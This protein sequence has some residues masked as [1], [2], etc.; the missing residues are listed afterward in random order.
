MAVDFDVVVVGELNVDLILRGD[1]TPAFGQADKLIDDA[2]LTIGSSSAICACGLARL[3][4]RVAFAGVVGGDLYGRYLKEALIGRGIDVSAVVTDPALKT[5]ITVIF[6]RENDRGSLT[7]SG[8]I[9][10]LRYAD[11]D[12]SLL[13]RAR[14]LHLG[15]YFMLDALRPD[16]PRLFGEARA[17]GLSVS[18]DT[19]YDP[20][21]EWGGGLA[22]ALAACDIF[23]PNEAE[24]RAITGRDSLADGLAA[25]DK[26]AAVAVK[27]G[28]RGAVARRDGRL[29][30]AGIVPVQVVDA[31][32][33]G[34]TFD[35][36]FICG[37]LAGFELDKTL[38]LAC[39][40][41]SLSTR[42]AGGTSAQPALEEALAYV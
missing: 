3:G 29:V 30:S 8:S 31:V 15:S 37:W 7:Y 4:L 11:L 21:E 25:L 2:T 1:V 5:G 17:R 36:G 12:L 34:D 35:A 20:R 18:M 28:E 33:A 9:G 26:P 41:G 10:A 19:N 6:A 39:A 16:V 24:L 23:M 40:C 22:E 38:R 14:H 42:A 32:G 13:A 27:L